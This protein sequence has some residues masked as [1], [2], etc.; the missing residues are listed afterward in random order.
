[1]HKELEGSEIYHFEE[2]DLRQAIEDIRD[3]GNGYNGTNN[4]KSIIRQIAMDDK[5]IASLMYEELTYWLR[6]HVNHS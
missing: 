5:P 2:K 3:I 1:M 4:L 6:S